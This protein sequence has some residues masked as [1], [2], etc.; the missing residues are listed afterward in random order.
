MTELSVRSIAQF[1]SHLGGLLH[2]PGEPGYE[3]ACTLFNAMIEKRPR[4]VA[5][6]ASPQDVVAALG[7]ARE[8]ALD[9]AVRAGGHSVAGLSLCDGG[10]VIDVRGLDAVE[11]DPEQRIAKVGGGASWAAVDRVTQAHGLATTGGRVSTTGVAGLTLGGGSGWLERLHGLTCDNLLAAELVTADGRPVRASALE[12]PELL[13]ALRGGGGNF[14]VVTSFEFRLHPVGPQVFGGLVMHPAARGP[15]LMRA[16]R[17]VMLSAPG[18]LSLAF[19]YMVAAPDDAEVPAEL[20]GQLV[21]VVAGMYA[22]PL[23]LGEELLAP[24]RRLGAPVDLFGPVQ[25]AEFQR[26]IDDPPGYRNYW[27]AEQLP[28]LPDEAVE[29]IHARAL[30]MPGSA[31]QIF[32]VAWGGAVCAADPGSSP[33]AG[34]DARFVVHPLMLWEDPADDDAVLAWGRSFRAGLRDFASGGSYLNFT[35]EQDDARVRAQFA[36]GCYERLARVKA[37]WD[38]ENVFRASGNVAPQR[39]PDMTDL[40]AR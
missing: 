3:D 29:L 40:D 32:C 37:T 27:T 24:I 25:Y 8:R 28:D 20:R 5:R 38:P 39:V 36:P 10:L 17:E 19:A 6:C 9:V 34:R 26:S 14:G 33:L 16:W 30:E 22:G 21:A 2:G 7:F 15:E 18:A 1:R 23:S 13:W 11:V 31:P 12:N 4:V 35:G